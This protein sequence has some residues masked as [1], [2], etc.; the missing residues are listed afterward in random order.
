MHEF[1]TKYKFPLLRILKCS[2]MYKTVCVCLHDAH[3]LGCHSHREQFVVLYFAQGHF[4]SGNQELNQRTTL[5][6]RDER[7]FRAELCR[8]LFL[9]VLKQN[10][11]SKKN[12]GQ[13]ETHAKSF[14]SAV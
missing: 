9:F 5:Q 7:Q 13:W 10:A 3:A 12:G 11:K 6:L 14:P 2:S 8:H 1:K 4:D